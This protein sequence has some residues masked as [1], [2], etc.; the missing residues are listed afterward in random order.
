MFKRTL[1]VVYSIL[2]TALLSACGSPDP[3]HDGEDI[4]Q[5]AVVESVDVTLLESFPVQANAVLTGSVPDGCTRIVDQVVTRENDTFVI[6]LKTSRFQDATC[7]EASAT[8]EHEVPLN[9]EGLP[10]GRYTVLAGDVST[11]FA[12]DVDN[13]LDEQATPDS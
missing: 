5:E 3:G 11:T 2:L 10:A 13:T 9:V 6:A 8:F 1:L 4:A 7:T 12:L